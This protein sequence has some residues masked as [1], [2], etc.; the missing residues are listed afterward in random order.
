[1]SKRWFLQKPF[2]VIKDCNL[3]ARSFFPDERRVNLGFR[4]I[5][6]RAPVIA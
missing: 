3:H 6:G 2:L 5:A 1:M 4:M